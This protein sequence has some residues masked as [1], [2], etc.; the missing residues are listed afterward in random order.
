[1]NKQYC[2]CYEDEINFLVT[3]ISR[4]GLS[5]S[6]LQVKMSRVVWWLSGRALDLRFAGRRF[7]SRPVR[8]H[9]T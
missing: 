5:I 8:F 6:L 4:N 9:I 3:I 7:N 1:M 2:C